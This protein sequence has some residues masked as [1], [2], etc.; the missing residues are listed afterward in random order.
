MDI[1]VK[2]R[3]EKLL[4][5][6]RQ[7]LF[8]RTD[9]MFA[10]LLA[11]QWLAGVAAALWIS[12]LAWVGLESHIHPHVWL[13]VVLGG[14]ID[15]LPIWMAIQM[16]GHVLTRHAIAVAQAFTSV[17][18]IHV[19]G[20]RIETHFHVFGSLAFLAVYRDWPVLI[21]ATVVTAVDHI[22][23]GAFWPESVY[24]VLEPGWWRWAEHAGW[25]VFEDVILIYS[26]VLG[27]R[28]MRNVAR[29]TAQLEDT[30]AGIERTVVQ[31]TSELRASEAELRRA[32]EAAESGSRAKG[33]FLA[34]M[35]HE[36]RTPM[37][38]I[39]GMTELALDTSLTSQQRDYL[40]SVRSSA[41]VL[42]SLINEILD[43]SK[44]EAGKLTLEEIP[45]ELCD[46]LEDTIK[47]L[48]LRAHQKGLELACHVMNDVPRYVLGDPIRLRQIIVNLVGNAIKF[49]EHGEVVVRVACESSQDEHVCLRFAI[50]DTG[51]GIPPEK[52][53][54]VFQ[55]FEQADQSTT[56]VYGGTGLGLAIVSRL[57]DLMGG[58]ISVDSQVGRGS[59]FHFSIRLRR[60]AA[61]EHTA[62]SVPDDWKDLRAL[63]VDDNATNRK[64][65]VEI[66]KSWGVTASA[67]ESGAAAL[68]ILQEVASRGAAFDFLLLDAQMPGMDGLE[69]AAE[70][71]LD[72]RFN[73]MGVLL[74]SSSGRVVQPEQ[75]ESL[76]LDACL[77]KPVK[78]SELF[79]AMLEA[80]G[81]RHAGVAPALRST[82]RGESAVDEMPA[83]RPLLI[84][85]AEDNPVNQRVARGI[86][87]KRGHQVVVVSNGREAVEAATLQQ[88]DLVLMDV[89]MPELDG[90]AATAEIRRQETL[91]GQYTPIVAM[92]AHAMASDEAR[93]L[94][95][96]MDG[97]ISKPVDVRKLLATIHRLARPADANP[98]DEGATAPS[99]NAQAAPREIFDIESVLARVEGDEDL[100]QELIALFQES[101]PLLIDEIESGVRG[102][103]APTVERAA[104]ALKGALQSIGA[105]SGAKA[106]AALEAAGRSADLTEAKHLLAALSEEYARLLAALPCH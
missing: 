35:S 16:P 52:Q 30:N 71:K 67:V 15:A 54:S 53:G 36:I 22:L 10:V 88:F 72:T 73:R 28:E 95:A 8:V 51:I 11:V 105:S 13:A 76:G 42:L 75:F 99:W 92:T 2:A 31:R 50:S 74:L 43:F 87:E 26:C 6:Q 49:T 78:R 81:R 18:L 4:N 56:R 27:V 59:T 24:G 44:I 19:T 3:T 102:S 84:L 40:E 85:L 64:I 104:H 97:Y 98:T 46:T 25:V 9:R 21:T 94:E 33:E 55:A 69:T 20:G 41:D 17:T 1:N 7:L 83:C 106:A 57:V 90:L 100:L 68:D 82:G 65:Y 62:L 12:P 45:F 38:G 66:L 96:G 103:D 63:V 86:L 39:I 91:S 101:A 29:R 70:V 5:E 77:V 47:P 23:R 58:E 79:N 32:K 93:C 89:Q 60:A 37:N 14:L 61:A 34:N 80:H 48:G